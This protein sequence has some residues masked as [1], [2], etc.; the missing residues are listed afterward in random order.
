MQGSGKDKHHDTKISLNSNVMLFLKKNVY[1]S[2]SLKISGMCA[3]CFEHIFLTKAY[4]KYANL[5]FLSQ[6]FHQCY[7][8]E[9]A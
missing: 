9:E 7:N 5:S 6:L 4:T 1:F 2:F 8:I 3:M